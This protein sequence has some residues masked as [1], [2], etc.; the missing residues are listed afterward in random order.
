D[1]LGA[2]DRRPPYGQRP[3]L[4]PD[5]GRR[6]RRGAARRRRFGPPRPR[7]RRAARRRLRSDRRRRRPRDR[8]AQGPRRRPRR[9]RLRRR[10]RPAQGR[11][12][13]RAHG[14]RDARADRAAALAATGGPATEMNLTGRRTEVLLVIAC[15]AAAVMLGVSE[16]MDTFHLTPPGGEALE[17]S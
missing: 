4:P 3:R 10:R 17:A 9:A 5:P 12:L 14:G 15:F 2:T 11:L 16:L 1:R 8:P 6:G 7:A 13:R